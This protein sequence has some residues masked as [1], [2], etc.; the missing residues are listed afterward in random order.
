MMQQIC[1]S[2]SI[3]RDAPTRNLGG[4]APTRRTQ[5]G[6]PHGRIGP[7]PP[8]HRADAEESPRRPPAKPG[9][10]APIGKGA[11]RLVAW[12]AKLQQQALELLG[13]KQR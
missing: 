1:G 2:V 4:A 13:T 3:T 9:A 5:K 11:G 10:P 6:D 7:P 12:L 8:G